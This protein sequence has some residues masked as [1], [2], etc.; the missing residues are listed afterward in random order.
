MGFRANQE[1]KGIIEK[2]AE[3][4][5]RSVSDAIRICTLSVAANKVMRKQIFGK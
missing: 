5:Q 2:L 3:E 4:T 1:E